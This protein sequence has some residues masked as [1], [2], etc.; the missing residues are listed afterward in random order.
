MTLYRLG[1]G[2]IIWASCGILLGILM[3]VGALAFER[4]DL[5]FLFFLIWIPAAALL[6]HL[7][8]RN[9][10]YRFDAGYPAV[11]KTVI[12]TGK[13]QKDLVQISQRAVTSTFKSAS[14]YATYRKQLMT[15]LRQVLAGISFK[16][17]RKDGRY[18]SEYVEFFDRL[19]VRWLLPYLQYCILGYTFYR[20]DQVPPISAADGVAIY[21]CNYRKLHRYA[22][23]FVIVNALSL[24]IGTVLF[25]FPFCALFGL[26]NWPAV[27][28]VLLAF[29]FAWALK[30]AF[31]DSYLQVRLMRVFMNAVNNTDIPRDLRPWLCSKSKAYRSMCNRGKKMAKEQNYLDE[32]YGTDEMPAADEP[33]PGV[34]DMYEPNGASGHPSSQG[35]SAYQ[36]QQYASASTTAQL[37]HVERSGENPYAQYELRQEQG[38]PVYCMKCGAK[39][40]YGS[41]HCRNC[42]EK[43]S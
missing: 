2:V 16:R 26:F 40:F 24:T 19:C 29:G 9:F 32:L 31:V 18:V 41:R 22:K 15:S 7:L 34:D 20:Y 38:R 12:V 27:L 3:A 43:L 11:I 8:R 14:Q 30:Y 23:S 35:F 13:V 21:F 1:T 10:A 39:N 6:I 4:T 25:S 42:G 37:T 17:R 28:A 36:S 5:L 33:L